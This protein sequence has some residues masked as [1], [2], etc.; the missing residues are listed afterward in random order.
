VFATPEHAKHAPELP[1]MTLLLQT[2]PVPKHT[3][4][5]TTLPLE[6]TAPCQPVLPMLPP[7]LKVKLCA[8]HG[9]CAM[10][11]ELE[12]VTL[13]HAQSL[14]IA[15]LWFATLPHAPN[16]MRPLIQEMNA[17]PPKMMTLTTLATPPPV[18][19]T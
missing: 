1:L 9:L 8:M 5:S 2:A 7:W 12:L 3:A 16:A 4:L 13:F 10:L 18:S 17:P 15:T 11:P 14:L 19:A 6:T